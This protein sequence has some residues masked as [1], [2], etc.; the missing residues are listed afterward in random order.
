MVIQAIISLV[1]GFVV[2]V[3]SGLVGVGGGT[4]LV[5]IFTVCFGM[6]PVMATGT[7]L[8]TIVFTSLAGMFA[9]L[10][11]HTCKVKLGLLLGIGGAL[12]SPLGS[13]AAT[14]SPEILV[15]VAVAAV[16]LYSAVSTLRKALRKQPTKP[17]AQGQAI[18]S[19]GRE[20]ATTA[21]TAA[22]AT[23][24]ASATAPTSTTAATAKVPIAPA[25]PSGSIEDRFVAHP[26]AFS[27][28]CLAIGLVTGLAS[29]Y[30]GLGGGFIMIPLMCNLLD[31]S[32]KDASG[33]SLL[34]IILIAASGSVAQF[35][36]GN[37]NVLVGLLIACGSIPGALVG[38]TL[39]SRFDDRVLRFVFAGFLM[40]AAVLLIVRQAGVLG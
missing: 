15:V 8:F 31:A 24:T 34:A 19:G 4:L 5:P 33:T 36:Y 38:G 29:G 28:K 12:T 9:R 25:V 7:S 40:V 22:A 14:Q 30:V 23:T 21:K 6:A 39:V 13:Y 20:A 16:I 10:R 35:V 18:G 2:G 27:L 1:V 17:K 32:M 26:V 37:V 3:F 11:N